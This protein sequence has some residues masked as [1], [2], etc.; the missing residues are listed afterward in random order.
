LSEH[1]VTLVDVDVSLANAPAFAARMLAWL[2]SEGIVGEGARAGDIYHDWLASFGGDLSSPLVRDD[3]VVHRPGP[4]VRRACDAAASLDV[5]KNWLGVD[6]E[7]QV[8][9]GG[10]HGI[11]IRCPACD[12]DQTE[13][14]GVWGPAIEDWYQGGDG[15]FRCDACGTTAPLRDWTF[16]PVWGFGNLGFRFCD[17][18]LKPDFIAAFEQKLGHRMKIVHAHL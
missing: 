18:I 2:Q 12:A 15:A 16:D 11:G 14:G 13:V 10:E 17:W 1:T 5:L 4:Q 9:T 7:R 6:I 8:F 3:R